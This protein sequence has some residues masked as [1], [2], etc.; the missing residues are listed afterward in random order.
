MTTENPDRLRLAKDIDLT[1]A[2]NHNRCNGSGISGYKT[3]DDPAH[4]GESLTVP[5]VCR[6]VT[7]RG[8]VK[9]DAFD[10]IAGDL[11]RQLNDGTFAV[12][13]ASDV[14]G[15]P[16]DARVKKIAELRIDAVD[17][18]KDGVVKAQIAEALKIIDKEN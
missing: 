18:K 16:D 14:M 6:C 15:L 2:K 8:G 9:K 12:N 3:M 4:P 11:E 13:L 17:D 1:T 10:R 7:R 5:I